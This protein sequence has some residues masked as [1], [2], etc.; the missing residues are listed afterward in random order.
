MIESPNGTPQGL[1]R[2][3][4]RGATHERTTVEEPAS[5]SLEITPSQGWSISVSCS[6]RFG[7]KQRSGAGILETHCAK[8]WNGQFHEIN[9]AQP[10]QSEVKIGCLTRADAV[11]NTNLRADRVCIFPARQLNFSVEN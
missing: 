10:W 11:N 8:A 9:S 2:R 4:G 1:K 6:L 7:F 3:Q 5:P